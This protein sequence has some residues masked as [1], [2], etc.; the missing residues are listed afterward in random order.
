MERYIG[1]KLVEA[2]PM[3]REEFNYLK[4]GC[5]LSRSPENGTP[6]YYV[7]YPDGYESWCPQAVF[8]ESNILLRESVPEVTPSGMRRLREDLDVFLNEEG[9][10]AAG[11]KS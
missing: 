2:E 7:R 8:E 10:L 5:V 1:V 11:A 6:G 3:T 4:R 9:G